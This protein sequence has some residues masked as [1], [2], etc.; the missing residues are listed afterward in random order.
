VVTGK[1]NG[2]GGVARGTT[3]RCETGEGGLVLTGGW[4]PDRQRPSHGAHR[5]LPDKGSVGAPDAWA[6]TGSRR[7]RERRKAAACGPAWGK[8]KCAEPTGTRDF[9]DLFK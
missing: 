3:W 1:G 4:R 9:F 5:W 2:G 7:E 6:L 8:E